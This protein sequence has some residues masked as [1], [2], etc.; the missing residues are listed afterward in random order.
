MSNSPQ[1]FFNQWQSMAQQYW[2]GW[3]TQG[4][5][6]AASAFGASAPWQAGLDQWTQLFQ[7]G[8]QQGDLVER[9]STNA[10][11][12]VSLMQSM[13][14][15]SLGQA[16]EGTT[17]NWT[18]ALKSGFNVPGMDASLWNNPLAANMRDLAG[19]GAKGFEQIMADMTRGAGPMREQILGTLNMPSFGLAREHQERWQQLA[20]AMIDYQEQNNRYNGLLMQSSQDGFSR[21]QS[22]LAEREEPGRQLESVRAVYDLWVDA[23]EEA[24]AQIALSQEFRK[25]YGSM[26]NAQMRVRSLM[27]KE[28]EQQT[29]QMGIPTRS[30]LAGVEKGLHELRRGAKKAQEEQGG[31]DLAAEVTSLRAEVAEL[32]RQFASMAKGTHTAQGAPAPTAAPTAAASSAKP[33]PQA[34]NPSKSSKTKR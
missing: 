34:G 20:S 23:A 21:F 15:A 8:T 4:V 6:P 19:P 27:Q 10:K 30:E 17:A 33:A 2:D 12:Y 3:K 25:V 7:Q 24:Y 13:L 5:S 9:V 29:R 11:A 1:D 26:V 14:G 31:A 16:G 18:D 28:V 32:K 22:K